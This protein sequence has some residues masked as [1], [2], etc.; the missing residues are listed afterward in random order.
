MVARATSELDGAAAD[1]LPGFADTTTPELQHL[2]EAALKSEL[3]DPLPCDPWVISPLSRTR[4][5]WDTLLFFCLGFELWV[6]PFDLIFLSADAMPQQMKDASHAITAI[7]AADILLNFN[8]GYIEKGEIVMERKAIWKKYVRFWFWMDLISS[9]P[10]DLILSLAAPGALRGIK[11][12]KGLR[13]IRTVRYLKMVKSVQLLATMR[14]LSFHAQLIMILQRILQ[15]FLP[16]WALLVI[17]HVHACL[18]AALQPTWDASTSLLDAL[19]TYWKMFRQAWLALF[20]AVPTTPDVSESLY[21]KLFLFDMFISVERLCVFVFGGIWAVL[22]AHTQFAD[23]MTM[24]KVS[25][26]AVEYLKTHK[27]SMETQI[28][29]RFTLEEVAKARMR[30]K[31]FTAL[32][33]A[34]HLTHELHRRICCEL[35]SARLMSL[36]LITHVAHFHHD[37][38]TELSMCVCEEVFACKTVLF[39]YGDASI[40]AYCVLQGKASVVRVPD[41]TDNIPEYT[42]GNWLGESALINPSLRRGLT[43]FTIETCHMM[44]I[45]AYDFHELLG[46]LNLTDAFQKFIQDHLWRGLCTRCGVLGDHF[47][48]ECPTFLGSRVSRAFGTTSSASAQDLGPRRSERRSGKPP[49]LVATINST[50]S[51]ILGNRSSLLTDIGDAEEAIHRDLH[52]FLKE[53]EL[54]DLQESLMDI[55]V[56]KLTDLQEMDMEQLEKELETRGLHLSQEQKKALSPSLIKRFRRSAARVVQRQLFGPSSEEHYIFLSH[57]KLEAGTEAALM[58][59]ELENLIRADPQNP[60]SSFDVPIFLD[61]EDLSDLHDLQNIVDRTHNLVLLLSPSVLQRVWV[62]VEITTAV[63]RGVRVLPVLVSKPGM[64]FQFPKDE[65]FA[66]F[67]K[68]EWLEE[69]DMQILQEARFT[70]EDVAGAI[71]EVF[72]HIA[73]PY[74]PHMAAHMRKAELECLMKRCRAKYEPHDGGAGRPSLVTSWSRSFAKS[75]SGLSRQLSRGISFSRSPSLS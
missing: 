3:E 38:I 54:L 42:V 36:G 63:N 22:V 5:L 28:Q 1:L 18:W 41:V 64:S 48:K 20:L 58:R 9:V 62:L 37:F 23:Y 35:W 14:K 52:A 44:A 10:V 60:A 61:S 6:T 65:F 12:G 67:V 73:V 71:R 21:Y 75:K 43:V 50:V 40:A 34:N 68:G 8:T 11:V 15:P 30:Q 24:T 56:V 31:H 53:K 55:G 25:D 17:G 59:N 72:K 45:P 27:I 49:P 7:F 69:S 2:F 19:Q 74:S 39:H 46:K 32:T 4:I 47:S 29:L 33:D 57:A 13:L 51:N 66:D 70:L 16:L 26:Y